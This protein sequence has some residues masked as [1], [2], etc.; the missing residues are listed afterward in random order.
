MVICRNSSKTPPESRKIGIGNCYKWVFFLCIPSP[1][2]CC[3][4]TSFV[5]ANT[6]LS[7]M[8][9]FFLMFPTRRGS[10]SVTFDGANTNMNWKLLCYFYWRTSKMSRQRLWHRSIAALKPQGRSYMPNDT[11]T[12]M[13]QEWGTQKCG[14]ATMPDRV[15]YLKKQ[16]VCVSPVFHIRTSG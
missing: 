6:T 7:V 8:D 2:Y 11:I 12:Y 5:S 9:W 3:R 4:W 13:E 14:F 16:H 15:G 10:I 1:H